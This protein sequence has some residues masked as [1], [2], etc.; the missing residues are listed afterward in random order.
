MTKINKNPLWIILIVLQL[1]ACS[2]GGIGSI[3]DG[4]IDGTGLGAG[5]ISS[6]GSIFVN[7][8]EYDTDSTEVFING[9]AGDVDQ[10]KLGMYVEV[11]GDQDVATATGTAQRVEYR[12]L[13]RGPIKYINEDGSF[14]RV[15]GS[16]VRLTEKTQVYGID[17]RKALKVGD[18]V[19]ISSAA[20]T[21]G[22]NVEASLVEY[23][24]QDSNQVMLVGTLLNLDTT[25]QVFYVDGQRFVYSQT[26]N[27][28]TNLR[29]RMLVEIL[30]HPN[31][32]PGSLLVDEIRELIP[33]PLA[34][35]SFVQ[36]DGYIT[37]YQDVNDFDV[38][39][40]P[41][42]LSPALVASLDTPLKQ[43]IPVYITGH[44]DENGVIVI[45]QLEVLE[46]PA[47]LQ[48]MNQ[49]LL[50]A[51][52]PIVYLDPPNRINIFGVNG[53]LTEQTRYV[54]TRGNQDYGLQD[55]R[56]G[57]RHVMSGTY[58]AQGDFEVA[59]LHRLFIRLPDTL[60]L[61]DSRHLQ[62]GFVVTDSI[63]QQLQ[64]LGVDVLTH[65]KTR[66]FDAS[67]ISDLRLPPP[68]P[69]L[70]APENAEV[71]A[72]VFF[73][74]LQNLPDNILF[75]TGRVQGNALAARELVLL[76]FQRPF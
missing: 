37:R 9:E 47:S 4:G 23:L 60:N 72:S 63:N 22:Q 40:R 69:P 48:D 3:A 75:V 44:T 29:N 26:P 51:T 49:L 73:D 8:I 55:L 68:G 38:Q 36:I 16:G 70:L 14:I 61:A 34:A 41:A 53:L 76:P 50:R 52:G 1:F 31:P 11:F 21:G 10:L 64:V 17:S 43:L 66:Y 12:D 56:T 59:M 2:G 54:D 32:V 27:L 24:P 74:Q 71:D 13:L 42:R 35:N 28:P 15:L 46:I 19:R 6:F 39:Y 7:D 33:T 67:A 57:D 62:G 20:L 45:E 65:T 30:A 25:A 18:R 58:N 5:S